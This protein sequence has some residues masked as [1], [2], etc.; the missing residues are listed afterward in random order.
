[1][2]KTIYTLSIV[3]MLTLAL[4]PVVVVAD[5]IDTGFTRSE[6][7]SIAPIIKAKWEMNVTDESFDNIESTSPLDDDLMSAYPQFMPPGVWGDY[8]E[9]Y[10]CAIATDPEGV[11]DIS[12]VY[13]DIFFPENIALG[14]CHEDEGGCGLQHGYEIQL[15]EVGFDDAYELFCENIR[16]NHPTLVGFNTGYDYDEICGEEGELMKQTAKVYCKHTS[17][18][19]EDPA[20]L[21]NVQAHA[22]DKAGTDSEA[23]FNTFEYLPLTDFEVDFTNVNY[24]EVRQNIHKIISGN[25]TF[26]VQDNKPTVRN[27]GNTRLNMTI[28]QDDMGLGKTVNGGE[29]W[30]VEWDAR[31]SSYAEFAVYEPYE[32]G[33]VL[34]NTLDLSCTEEMDF[35]ILVSKFPLNTGTPEGGYTGEMI[36]GAV[37]TDFLDCNPR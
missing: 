28:W 4:S 18:K 12:A 2:K 7:G 20:G 33:V 34:D 14:P 37:Y 26:N 29:W 25:K 9:I 22:V 11:S 15:V 27:T 21:Y 24:G 6:G 17:L 10:V 36:L 5:T 31:V 23:F 3:T 35:S 30:N 1:M 32:E 16:S 13:A 19:W 8:K